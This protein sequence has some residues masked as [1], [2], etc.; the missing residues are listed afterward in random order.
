M[1]RFLVSK[2]KGQYV[3]REKRFFLNKVYD[4]RFQTPMAV[5]KYLVS[6]Y[7][8]GKIGVA[9]DDSCTISDV[10]LKTIHSS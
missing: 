10:L 7:P 1:K 4:K 8:K 6:L 3:I 9:F 5:W 2:E